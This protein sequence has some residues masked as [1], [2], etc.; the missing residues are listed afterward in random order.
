MLSSGATYR[1]FIV[2]LSIALSSSR[3]TISSRIIISLAD[4]SRILNAAV[5][6][7]RNCLLLLVF[8][9]F[10]RLFVESLIR[11][12]QWNYKSWKK[13][14][15][16]FHLFSFNFSSVDFR[17]KLLIEASHIF[18]DILLTLP[19]C[20]DLF[21]RLRLFSSENLIWLISKEFLGYTFRKKI[22][23]FRFCF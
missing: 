22:L 8:F 2:L 1:D 14:I 3:I 4:D 10:M 23:D 15:Y 19:T 5:L 16:H 13:S 9:L 21:S 6:T 18:N 17:R 20:L 7:F 12:S 11:F